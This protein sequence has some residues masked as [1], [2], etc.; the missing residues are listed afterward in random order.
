MRQALKSFGRIALDTKPSQSDVYTFAAPTRGLVTNQN[1]SKAPKEAAQVLENW[2]PTQTGIKLRGGAALFATIGTDPVSA[3]W[4]YVS[5]GIEKLFV[6]DAGSIFN[7]TAPADPA[8]APTADV[9]G[10]SGGAWTFK[11]FETSGGDY[12]VGVNGADTP[13]QY[14]G[15]TWSSSSMTGSGLTTSNLSHV[16][17]F[18]ARLFFIESGTMKFWYLGAGAITGTAT[19]FSLQGVFSKGGSLLFGASWSLDAGDGVDDLFVVVSTLGEVAVYQGTNPS[20]DFRLVGRYQIAA[21]MGKDAHLNVGADLLILTS[22]GIIPMSQVLQKD[23]TSLSLSAVTFM[24]EPTWKQAARDRGT[25]AWTI[26]KWDLRNMVIVGMPSPGAG[27]DE[28][29]LVANAETGAWTEF[30][31]TPWDI[32]CQTVLEGVHYAGGATGKI[33]QTDVGGNDAGSVYTCVCVGHNDHLKRRGPVKSINLARATFKATRAFIARVSASVNY[34][35]TLP[36]A[37]SSVAESTEDAWDEGLW[38]TAV[39]DASGTAT[40]TSRWTAISK[41]GIVAAPQVQVTC[42]ITPK[43]DAELMTIDFMFETGDVVV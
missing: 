12:L 13:R 37:P 11:Q 42:G 38:D 2:L 33:Y 20:S 27:V 6:A 22:E 5:G 10:L 8:V 1:L 19:A 31:G 4:D 25:L 24:I 23:P 41:A 35:I 21:P 14:D 17:A 40:V 7:I 9:T 30:T 15:T 3:L 32:R 29:C 34:A 36:A 26:S 16:W 18:K 43:P 39:W 28:R